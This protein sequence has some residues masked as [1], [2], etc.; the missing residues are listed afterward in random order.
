MTDKKVRE[1]ET[2]KQ[3]RFSLLKKKEAAKAKNTFL[4]PHKRFQ[5][6]LKNI[7]PHIGTDEEKVIQAEVLLALKLEGIVGENLTKSD[8]KLIRIIKETIL[9]DANKK[10]EALLVA[11]RLR[12]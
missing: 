8:T 5:E 6:I 7:L 12:R 4:S 2:Q 10:E 1:L 11:E 3:K 9:V